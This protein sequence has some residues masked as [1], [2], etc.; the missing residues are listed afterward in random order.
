VAPRLT[1]LALLVVLVA[2]VPIVLV[3]RRPVSAADVGWLAREAFPARDEAAV[4]ERYLT[5]H[6]RHRAAGGLFGAGFAILTGIT[7]YGTVHVGIGSV[8]PFADVLWCTVA[9]ILCG[10][11]SAEAFRFDRPRRR[12][13]RSAASLEPH[14]PAARPDLARAARVLI[15]CS[16]VVAIVVGGI[17]GI[18]SL[19]VLTV[20]VA[21]AAMV[22]VA[23]L[24]RASIAARRRPVMTDA[25]ARVDTHIRE[26]AGTAVAR[27][28]LAAA[29]LTAGWVVA[30]LPDQRG[31]GDDV[32]RTILTLGALV[33]TVVLL[34]RA[35]PR[36]P[37]GWLPP[38]ALA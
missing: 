32:V 7:W 19:G 9:G 2:A 37:R 13:A 17:W 21:G 10:A 30:G 33:G 14:A 28:E 35:A 11:L 18:G 29:V 16:L 38:G 31:A 20:A 24:T 6:R 22:A 25:A 36:A 3:V 26:F 4:Y 5:R 15:G 8:S 34:R 12:S 27:L 23:E 1:V